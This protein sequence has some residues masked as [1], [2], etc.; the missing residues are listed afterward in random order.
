MIEEIDLSQMYLYVSSKFKTKIEKYVVHS[1]TQL[2]CN[3][4][5]KA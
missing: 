1:L 2:P 4:R 5:N 3:R